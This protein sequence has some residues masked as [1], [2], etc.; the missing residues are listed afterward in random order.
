MECNT[1]QE[2]MSLWVDNKLPQEDIR[3]IEVH[4]ASCLTCRSGLEAL[5]R[6]D[7]LLSSTPMISPAHSFSARFQARLVARKRAHR[8]WAGL[9][10]LALSGLM[11]MLGATLLL[12]ISGIAVWDSVTAS[13]LLTQ[14]IALLLDVGKAM[15]ASLRLAWLVVKALAR[16]I[17]HPVFVAYAL[18]TAVLIVGW[19]QTINRHV[20][21][22]RPITFNVRG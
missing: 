1:Y 10:I 12:A 7:R 5:R 18:A 6:V 19:T 11:V 2:Q 15:A 17:R 3:Q 4:I 20:L 9:T 21:A 16:G 13:G 14:S 22:R 8:T